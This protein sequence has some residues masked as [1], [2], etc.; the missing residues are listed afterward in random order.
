MKC[1]SEQEVTKLLLP[2]KKGYMIFNLYN[3][4]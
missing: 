3:A 2:N 4:F 1:T